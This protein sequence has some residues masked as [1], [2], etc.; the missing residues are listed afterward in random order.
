MG[1]WLR[2]ALWDQQLVGNWAMWTTWPRPVQTG[3]R[4]REK[5]HTG[6]CHSPLCIPWH[7]PRISA[8]YNI[9]N[10]TCIINRGC[11]TVYCVYMWY[12]PRY[13]SPHSIYRGI[14]HVCR[15]LLLLCCYTQNMPWHSHGLWYNILAANGFFLPR[16]KMGNVSTPPTTFDGKCGT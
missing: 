10:T 6:A 7:R 5:T 8:L 15:L 2:K 16:Q 11:A 4:A 1:F 14:Y 12:M 13:N 3:N 9:P